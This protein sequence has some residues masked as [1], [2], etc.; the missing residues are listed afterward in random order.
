MKTSKHWNSTDLITK[1]D[2][3]IFISSVI[4]NHSYIKDFSCLLSKMYSRIFLL[5]L[6][7]YNTQVY[8]IVS[9]NKYASVKA[10]L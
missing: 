4:Y 5:T 1:G 8:C 2:F 3:A 9:S 7:L 10:Y 6:G